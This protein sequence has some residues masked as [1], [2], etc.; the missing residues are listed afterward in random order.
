MQAMNELPKKQEGL[1]FFGYLV[2][3]IL[4]VICTHVIIGRL[5]SIMPSDSQSIKSSVLGLT[6]TTP[7]W[8]GDIFLA[9]FSL[10]FAVGVIGFC[11]RF[12]DTWYKAITVILLIYSLIAAPSI[13]TWYSTNYKAAKVATT[14]TD[15]KP[16]DESAIK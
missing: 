7:Y 2:L 11:F 10:V 5:L 4:G 8:I 12:L 6:V 9:I 1:G 14:H 16:F 15:L 13:K 3:G